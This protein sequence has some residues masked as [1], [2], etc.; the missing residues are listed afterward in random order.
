MR[1]GARNSLTRLGWWTLALVQR[2]GPGTGK[3]DAAGIDRLPVG[4]I[5][6][7]ESQSTWSRDVDP[8]CPCR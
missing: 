1:N 6:E 5:P 8:P 2:L 3:Y 7:L 4:H